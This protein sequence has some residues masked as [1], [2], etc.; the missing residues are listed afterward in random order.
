MIQNASLM[1]AMGVR[2]ELITISDSLADQWR[3]QVSPHI[4]LLEGSPSR[5]LLVIRFARALRKVH[6]SAIVAFDLNV[7]PALA[8][9]SHVRGRPRLVLDLHNVLSSR[10]G[11]R[12]LRRMSRRMDAC[13]AVS[14]YAAAQVSAFVNTSVVHRAI[15][16]SSP[17]RSFTGKPQ[18]FGIVGRIDPDKRIDLVAKAAELAQPSSL[19][20]VRGSTST[21][22][23]EYFQIVVNQMKSILGPRLV[24]EGK[25]SPE[26]ALDGIDVLIFPN[27]HE[28]SGRIVA[29]AQVMGIPVIAPD[30]G[31]VSEF[32]RPGINGWMFSAGDASSL[33]KTWR[34]VENNDITEVS[35]RCAASSRTAYDPAA[36]TADYT[37][38]VLGPDVLNEVSQ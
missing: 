23:E 17:P 28:P 37:R 9:L 5:G 1:S 29:E 6:G 30:A 32:V 31:G 3:L 4:T 11:L 38:A 18:T 8:L 24:I 34:E 22:G 21:N 12:R 27:D 26:K 7:L 20:L 10:R 19:L 33:A 25:S 14:N 2:C 15:Q 35:A 13:V 16:H 36:R